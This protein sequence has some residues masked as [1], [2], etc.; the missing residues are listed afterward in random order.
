MSL[1]LVLP[2]AEARPAPAP[3]TVLVT[4]LRPPHA[5]LP[6]E[7]RGGEDRFLQTVSQAAAAFEGA[8]VDVGDG[9]VRVGFPDALLATR[10]ALALR[11]RS[12][13]PL[14]V[15]ISPSRRETG[16]LGRLCDAIAAATPPGGLV[17]DAAI[18]R[19][20]TAAGAPFGSI[21]QWR[22]PGFEGRFSL[23]ALDDGAGFGG[24]PAERSNLPDPVGAL[25][26]R[27]SV[28]ARLRDEI[29]D[30]ARLVSLTGLP[31]SGRRRVCA[32]FASLTLDEWPGGAWTVDAGD[33]ASTTG[34]THRVARALGAPA[35]AAGL[36]GAQDLARDI[37][38]RGRTLI[39]LERAHRQD[40]FA[41][42]VNALVRGAP[43]LVLLC[44][45]SSPIGVDGERTLAL[46][47]LTM[48][49]A[50]ALLRLRCAG[51]M[52]LTDLDHPSTTT[53]IERVDRAPQAIEVLAEAIAQLGPQ[54][55]LDRVRRDPAAV[56]AFGASG[57]ALAAAVD[58]ALVVLPPMARDAISQLTAFSEDFCP[59]AA[60]AVI[61][62][63]H[64]SSV[65]SPS[66]MVTT[67]REHGLVRER[68]GPGGFRLE[69]PH[70]VRDR[71][72][73]D[74]DAAASSTAARA[75]HAR[76]FVAL[77]TTELDAA[78]RGEPAALARLE[79]DKH[80][81]NAVFERTL[82]PATEHP[83]L[84]ALDL[85]LA[86]R[87]SVSER[88]AVLDR[89]APIARGELGDD[90]A[91]RR[92][93]C[94]LDRGALAEAAEV[95]QVI[96]DRLTGRGASPREVEA[97]LVL[98]T[99]WARNGK[100]RAGLL[101]AEDALRAARRGNL[102][103]WMSTAHRAMAEC[104][105]GCGDLEGAARE[106]Q[107]AV[108][109]ARDV[110]HLDAEARASLLT[111]EI[112]LSLGHTDEAT[113]ALNQALRH[114]ETTADPGLLAGA[115]ALQ[116]RARLES[117]AAKP[118]EHA[119]SK[120]VNLF[121]G[122]GRRHGG[123]RA[124]VLLARSI[125]E[126]GRGPEAIDALAR[127]MRELR[128]LGALPDEAWARLW[129]AGICEERG[130]RVAARTWY[131]EARNAFERASHGSGEALALAAI[132]ALDAD[133]GRTRSAADALKLARTRTQGAGPLAAQVLDLRAAR[134][135]VAELRGDRDNDG[136]H[137]SALQ[138]RIEAATEPEDGGCAWV[139]RSADVR[140]SLR[141]L[142][143]ALAG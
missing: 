87:G 80:E 24:L 18:A 119:L 136:A 86:R 103:T 14:R 39:V 6:G 116:G 139:A 102:R 93:A 100:G 56:F 64:L 69:I 128:E 134:L 19:A 66:Q 50:L 55:T 34:L 97:R 133:E 45:A 46:P 99:A 23:H 42:V 52:N 110:G 123:A 84:G 44:A 105:L 109:C 53:L 25:I 58:S 91:L 71:L 51:R 72:A 36:R 7:K 63:T 74:R 129:L 33:L 17:V 75:R 127:A 49:D 83:I 77:A 111:A 107:E 98:A 26:G 16:P 131:V 117:G 60:G 118:A 48:P 10:F 108:E 32:A 88:L 31:G 67:L 115:Y 95:A 5:G 132:A 73:S 81:L 96:V 143:R 43:D 38:N 37:A 138:S 35:P 82:R 68:P 29:H 9:R 13:E 22:L 114:A 78:E 141:L 135:H 70:L 124:D 4:A 142:E 59:E 62:A 112:A 137:L 125:A 30:G 94:L 130:N 79:A 76:Y 47:Q 12:S 20:A 1:T 41:H 140:G 92:A 122:A 57:G 61:R 54:E 27:D 104:L 28:V 121:R 120:A 113:A 11:G 21:G 8:V 15:A 2:P 3:P 40:A 101:E 106:V 89:A 90:V 85:V 126:Q 65:A